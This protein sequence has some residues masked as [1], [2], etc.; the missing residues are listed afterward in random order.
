MAKPKSVELMKRDMVI[1]QMH[2]D[3][4]SRREIA[5]TFGL[6]LPRVSQIISEQFRDITDDSTRDEMRAYLEYLIEVN[7]KIVNNP[8]Q[9]VTVAGKL[10]YEPLTDEDGNPLL[11][12]H[13]KPVD[14][15]TKPVADNRA[16]AEAMKNIA[17]LSDRLA[18]LYAW[19]RKRPTGADDQA[20]TDILQW[21]AEMARTAEN[22]RVQSEELEAQKKELEARLEHYEAP[23]GFEEA[24]VIEE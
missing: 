1:R 3:G 4:S 2:T 5:D 18:K 21:A 16:V 22:F 8:P 15:L 12:S 19:D 13:G 17:N 20:D 24:Q 23:A 7:L 11:T 9:M 6:S 10:V 14:D